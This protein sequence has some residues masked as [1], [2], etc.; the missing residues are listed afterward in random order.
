LYLHGEKAVKHDQ[1]GH[2]Q[3]YLRGC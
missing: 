3:L 2:S 1:T